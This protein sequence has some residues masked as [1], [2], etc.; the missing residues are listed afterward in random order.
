MEFVVV[1]R[2]IA[3]IRL[4]WGS[5]DRLI[6]HRPPLLFLVAVPIQGL[7]GLAFS[8]HQF[9]AVGFGGF[10]GVGVAEFALVVVGQPA[11]PAELAVAAVPVEVEL[12]GPAEEQLVGPA[13]V[14]PAFVVE[15]AFLPSSHKSFS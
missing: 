13:V 7:A 8:G 11:V 2:L 4:C 15:A 1:L 9:L 3:T 6:W 12:V 5:S 14:G 10:G